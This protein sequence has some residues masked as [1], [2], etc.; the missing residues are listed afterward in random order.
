MKKYLEILI[1][2]SLDTFVLRPH[3]GE[4][5]DTEHLAAAYLTSLG[6][7]HGILLRKVPALQY[8]YYLKQVGIA[9]SPLSNNAL[10]LNYERNPFPAYFR[11][12][13][14]VSLSTDDPLQFHYTKEPL[15][16]EYSVAA[17]IWKLSSSDLS[18]ISRNS[19]LQSG[20]EMSIKKQWLGDNIDLAPHPSSNNIKKSNVPQIRT[21]F[22]YD[23]LT[24]ER[25]WILAHG[26]ILDMNSTT[27]LALPATAAGSGGRLATIAST[28]PVLNHMAVP[29][30]DLST[31]KLNLDKDEDEVIE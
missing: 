17:Q 5:G 30:L 15:I 24:R 13:M 14:N 27:S 8:L 25:D 9:M 16:E 23:T 3:S 19:V 26:N 2:F 6:I 31:L 7:S 21:K 12:G 11:I 18:E 1:F 20:F 28:E 4:A 10:F 22:R 29:P